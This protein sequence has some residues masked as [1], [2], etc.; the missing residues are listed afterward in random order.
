SPS[1]SAASIPSPTA[2][3][4]RLR[5][6]TTAQ[7]LTFRQLRS[8]VSSFAS[9]LSRLGIR[10][11]DVVL[12]FAPN[13]VLFP[14]SFLSIISLGA[15][16]TTVNPLY[17]VGELKK[18]ALDSGA[19]LV[20]T[21]PDLV[22]KVSSLNLPIILLAENANKDVSFPTFYDLIKNQSPSEFAPPEINQ[23]DTVALLYSS[24]TTGASKGVVL[25]HRNFISVAMMAVQDQDTRGEPPNI[26]LC[27][28]PMFHIFG[29]S[30][31]TFAQLAR[32]NTVVVMKRFDME[33]TLRSI[34]RYRVSYLFVVPPVMIA[35]AKQGK[36]TKYDLSSLRRLGSGA[37]PLGKDVMEEVAGIF[38][39]ADIVQGYGLTESCGIVSLELPRGASLRQYGSTG[40]LVS[41]VEGKVVS[42]DTLRSLPPNQ[43]GELC[44]RGP[45]MMRGYFNNSQASKLTKDKEGW[46]HTGDLG[47]FNEEGQLFVVDRIKELIKYKGFQEFDVI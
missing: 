34:E 29:L 32:G 22:P 27:F 41:G 43:L 44:F 42:V 31:I 35:L 15:I 3:P 46:L 19:K 38:P 5:L 39:Q 23:D 6:R 17:T 30:V 33:M 1:S 20:L 11:G 18:Q 13:S 40:N 16:A 4:H 37:A 7:T 8:A 36:V 2:R 28:L 24:G 47:Y 12:I 14:V 9:A 21:V 26:F 25:T 45:N 10:K